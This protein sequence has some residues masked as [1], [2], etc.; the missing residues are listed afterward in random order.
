MPTDLLPRLVDAKDEAE[1]RRVIESNRERL[2]TGE[3]LTLLK[4]ESERYLSVD[5]HVALRLGEVLIEVARAVG[6][7]DHAALGVLATGDALFWLGRFPEALAL[8]ERGGE[9]LRALGDEV[10]WARSRIGWVRAMHRLGRARAA[11]ADVERAQA[12]LAGCGNWYRAGNLDLNTASIR[13]ELGDFEAALGLLDRARDAFARL[14]ETGQIARTNINRA[15]L[16]TAMGDFRGALAFHAEARAEYEAR[17]EAV[18][19][20]RSDYHVASVYTGQGQFTRALRLNAEVF[21]GLEKAGLEVEAGWVALNMLEC[22]LGL[23]RDDEARALAEETATRF[24]QFGTPT[25]TAK[26][27]FYSAVAHARLGDRRRALERLDQAADAFAASG[28]AGQLGVV[29]LHRAGL[30]LADRAWGAALAEAERAHAVFS[31]RGM[32][33]RQAQADLAAARALTGL[34]EQRRAATRARAALSL[35]RG[36]GAAWLAHEGHH[37]L[38]GVAR[39]QGR[40]DAAL[41]GYDRALAAVERVQSRLATELRTNFLADKLE[42]YHDAI[43]CALSATQPER[44]FQYLERAKSAALVDYLASNLDVRLAARNGV[45]PALEGRLRALREEH[46]WLYS[47]LNGHGLAER[48][49]QALRPDDAVRLAAQLRDLER[50]IARLLERI[51][52]ESHHAG[53]EVTTSA[54]ELPSPWRTL[55]DGVGLVEYH[56]GQR[57]GVAFV[58]TRGD[59]AAVP[60]EVGPAGIARLMRLWQLNLSASARAVAA[61]GPTDGLADSARTLLEALYQALLGPLAARLDGLSRLIVVPFGLTHGVPFHALHDGR[62]HLLETVEVSAAPSSAVHQICARRAAPSNQ[63][64]LALACSDGGRLR[65]VV[66]ES[67]AVVSTLGGRALIESEATR[68]ELA[69]AAGRHGVLHLA[70]HGEARL[71]NPTFAHV[72]LADG[73][74]TTA[75]IFNL[76]LEGALVVLSACESGRAAVHG[77][78]ELVGL[79]RG[80]LYAGAAALV[81]SLWRVEDGST[82]RLMARFYRALQG[83][84][85]ASAALREAQ[86]SS[87]EE[88]GHPFLWAPFQLVGDGERALRERTEPKPAP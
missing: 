58:A 5:P 79:T 84:W 24:E 32:A 18:N 42:V 11:M 70:A 73:P 17:G 8:Y 64:A 49:E 4:N 7:P 20:L 54:R 80:F 57:G 61:A 74:L 38:A 51:A 27:Q 40:V 55:D 86:L 12:I 22:Y 62:R 76:P 44:A 47:R 82:A 60:L 68:A 75:D 53:G 56:F 21:A 78:D 29:S 33:V 31:A 87:L 71:D 36:R 16:L 41:T 1:R 77:G 83:G 85:S 26:A 15:I 37:I 52:L 43:D 6:R 63:T 34:D 3:A 2:A 69:A 45:D 50:D 28:Q 10:G 46:A 81:Q 67:Q 88:D 9:E 35:A 19:L 65:H 23:N 13:Y 66:G 59:L 48:P 14:G 25:E 39:A 72:K 30:H